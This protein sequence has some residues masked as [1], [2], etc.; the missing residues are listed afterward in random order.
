MTARLIL[1][2]HGE[3][4]DHAGRCVGHHDTEL[5][6]AAHE[7]L[8]RLATSSVSAPSIVVASDLQRAANSAAILARAW[9]AELRF[10]PRLRELSFGAWE[11]RPWEEISRDDP[12]TMNAWGNDWTMVSPP[13]GES[14]TALAAR[15]GSAL[16]DLIALARDLSS[17][18]AVVSHAGW[19]RVAATLLLR[20]PLRSAFDRKIDY[21]CVAI[22]EVDGDAATLTN[23]NV[24]RVDAPTTS[25]FALPPAP[26]SVRL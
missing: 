3:P 19:M 22:F 15:V 14:G 5:A 25:A 20:E 2:R 17:D 4:L 26:P 24:D 11:G 10:D 18:V 21:A 9:K 13:G 1:I 8:R 6:P 23:W 16:N 12:S 7:P